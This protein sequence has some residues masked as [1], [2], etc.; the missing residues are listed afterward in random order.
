MLAKSY[1]LLI[2]IICIY[3]VLLSGC[4]VRVLKKIPVDGTVEYKGIVY[5]EN[6]GRCPEGKIIKIT[7]GD[8]N[9]QIPRKYEC[10]ERP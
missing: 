2:L 10:V 4:Q 7:G 5:V 3:F 9:K 8:L 1:W 6:D